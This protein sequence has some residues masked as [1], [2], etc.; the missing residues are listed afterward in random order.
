MFFVLLVGELSCSFN[1]LIRDRMVIL[2][3]G[4]LYFFKYSFGM[5]EITYRIMIIMP[6]V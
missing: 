1:F 4:I 3:I 2:V 5:I 6:L